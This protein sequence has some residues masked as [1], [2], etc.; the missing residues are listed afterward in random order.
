MARMHKWLG[1]AAIG[2]MLTGC[3]SQEKYNA[4]KLRAD[5][6]AEQASQSDADSQRKRAQA[7][8]YKSQLDAIANSGNTK[9]AMLLNDQQQ[10]SDMR[11]QLASIQAKYEDELSRPPQVLATGSA[12][13]APADQR[14]ERL[15][16][17]ESRRR[18]FRRGAGRGEV[19]ERRDLRAGK[20]GCQRQGEGGDPALRRDSQFYRRQRI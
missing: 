14:A 5:S 13:P 1:L 17:R 7:D 10:I 6:L 4:M 2:L 11:A 19:Q 16:G 8:A 9:D 18:R 12:L 3:V 20:R 15:R